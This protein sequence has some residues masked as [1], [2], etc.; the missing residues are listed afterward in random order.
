MEYSSL[1]L[2]C[3]QPILPHAKKKLIGADELGSLGNNVIDGLVNLGLAP[4]SLGAAILDTVLGVLA[5]VGAV[6]TLGMHKTIYKASRSF[7]LSS[8]RILVQ[9]YRLL[10]KTINPHANI[11]V[12]TQAEI[13]G[14]RGHPCPWIYLTS[15]GLLTH[16][17]KPYLFGKAMKA[18]L[19]EDFTSR[20]ITSRFLFTLSALTCLVTRAVDGMIAMP[21]A[22][23]SILTFGQMQAINTLAVNALQ[24]PGIVSD[25]SFCAINALNPDSWKTP[26]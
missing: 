8:S 16:F 4:I 24:A 12:L 14:K 19:E 3:V 7:T 25:L 20:H 10:L 22:A 17:V 13:R 2:D 23:L 1:T 26:A 15:D 9:P 21:L 11:R 6:V 18:C 5:S